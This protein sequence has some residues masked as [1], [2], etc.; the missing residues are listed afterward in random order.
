MLLKQYMGENYT[1]NAYIK[2][3][4]KSYQITNFSL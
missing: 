4:K 3:E 2:K 1:V